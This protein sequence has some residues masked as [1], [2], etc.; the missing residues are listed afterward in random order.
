MSPVDHK[1]LPQHPQRAKLW[2]KCERCNGKNV[3]AAVRA[4]GSRIWVEWCPAKSHGGRSPGKGTLGLVAP[5]FPGSPL[6]AVNSSGTNYREH[7]CP[8]ALQAHSAVSFRKKGADLSAR[9]PEYFLSD[10]RTPK[11]G[12]RK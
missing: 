10:I 1:S 5:L 12:G 4:D 7:R 2:K 9:S 6:L 11:R 8:G 3:I